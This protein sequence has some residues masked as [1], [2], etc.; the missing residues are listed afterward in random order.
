[1]LNFYSSPASIPSP[2]HFYKPLS[3]LLSPLE[4]FSH[5]D[6]SLGFWP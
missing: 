3:F 6:E 5:Y 1:M 2:V 4:A